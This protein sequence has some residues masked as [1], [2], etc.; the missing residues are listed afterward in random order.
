MLIKL[1]LVRLVLRV[2]KDSVPSLQPA[3]INWLSL[4][5]A[6]AK[7]GMLCVM[8]CIIVAVLVSHIFK[9]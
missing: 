8:V 5:N 9:I 7:I 4:D 6:Q 1:V 3:T 2:Y